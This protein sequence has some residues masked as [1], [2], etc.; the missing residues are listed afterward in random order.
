VVSVATSGGFILTTGD[1]T[2]D[3]LPWREL[4]ARTLGGVA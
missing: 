3:P 2:H 1:V 4:L